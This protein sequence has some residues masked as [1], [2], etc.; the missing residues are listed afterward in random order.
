[1]IRPTVAAV[2]AEWGWVVSME[3]AT[4]NSALGLE[5][6]EAV[7]LDLFHWRAPRVLAGADTG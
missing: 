5:V 3:T 4:P 1:M 7:R 2:D 6:A